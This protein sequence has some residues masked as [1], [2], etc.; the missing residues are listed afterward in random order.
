M[1][2]RVWRD[3]VG[4][5]VIAGAILLS[6]PALIFTRVTAARTWLLEDIHVSRVQFLVWASLALL[7]GSAL[8]WWKTSRWFMRAQSSRSIETPAASPPRAPPEPQLSANFTP[9]EAQLNALIQLLIAHPREVG[10]DELSHNLN[11]L[12]A[13][14][15]EC[16]LEELTATGAVK[17]RRVNPQA[18]YYSLTRPGR[19]YM[20]KAR[21]NS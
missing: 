10:L 20:V 13:A 5:Q 14:E 1:V 21:Q 12:I 8:A 11:A 18:A 6:I 16:V 4:S 15:V 7:A 3:P 9:T 2:K 19:D 17:T